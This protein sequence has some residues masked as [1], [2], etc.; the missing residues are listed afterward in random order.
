MRNCC[1]EAGGCVLIEE[2]SMVGVVYG[3]LG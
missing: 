2:R 1:E 3:G